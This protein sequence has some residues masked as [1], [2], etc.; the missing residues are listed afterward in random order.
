MLLLGAWGEMIHEKTLIKKSRDTVSFS[1][2]SKKAQAE[3]SI[4]A[5]PNY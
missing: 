2:S 5:R 3:S 1:A 4:T